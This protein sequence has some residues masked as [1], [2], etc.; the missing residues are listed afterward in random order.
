MACVEVAT[1]TSTTRVF[2]MLDVRLSVSGV[3]VQLSHRLRMN[4]ILSAILS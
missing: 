4:Y 1:I 2:Q 3:R